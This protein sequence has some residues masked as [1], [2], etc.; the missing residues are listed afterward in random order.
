MENTLENDKIT[1]DEPTNAQEI[2]EQAVELPKDLN[3]VEAAT[4]ENAENEHEN[5]D[6]DKEENEEE[7]EDESEE[8][9]EDE[10]DSEGEDEDDLQRLGE[11]ASEYFM[12]M[13]NKR[14]EMNRE[15][16][17]EKP[18][19]AH[20]T[21]SYESTQKQKHEN[22]YEKEP[23][24]KK[25]YEGDDSWKNLDDK[26]YYEENAIKLTQLID[27]ATTEGLRK[28]AQMYLVEGKM[29]REI[30]TVINTYRKRAANS[31]FVYLEQE[32]YIKCLESYVKLYEE[33]IPM[34]NNLKRAL[35]IFLRVELKKWLDKNADSPLI[36]VGV[37]FSGWIGN[38][39]I[40]AAA[41]KSG[42]VEPEIIHEEEE[43]N[44]DDEYEYQQGGRIV[45]IDHVQ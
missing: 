6:S 8:E 15:Q 42:L 4:N 43:N 44:D 14:N 13:Q 40:K 32:E 38:L 20:N 31:E 39:G 7:N 27:T 34:P 21:F 33:D 25:R 45:S 11:S 29:I 36:G 37:A 26:D 9:N 18:P 30:K 10:D 5:N 3:D 23:E 16:Y 35:A 12:R 28:L 19:T 1:A 2:E 22:A 41:I 17:R 24:P